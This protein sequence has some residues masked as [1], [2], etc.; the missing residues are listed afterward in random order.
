MFC[1]FEYIL[2]TYLC[3]KPP[4]SRPETNHRCWVPQVEAIHPD[5]H[6]ACPEHSSSGRANEPGQ[7]P[8]LPVVDALQVQEEGGAGD[9]EPGAKGET[10]N[11]TLHQQALPPCY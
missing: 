3:K 9:E 4:S 5:T 11:T 2:S 8:V 1:Y 10:A 6:G 7:Q